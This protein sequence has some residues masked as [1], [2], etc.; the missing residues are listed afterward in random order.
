MAYKGGIDYTDPP[1]ESAD[2][3]TKELVPPW[4]RGLN[5]ANR[6]TDSAPLGG[7][8]AISATVRDFTVAGRQPGDVEL[9]YD[10][11]RTRASDGQRAQCVVVAKGKEGRTDAEKRCY[12]LLVT[13][14]QAVTG[15]RG[16]RVYERVGAGYML[17][18]YITLGTAGIAAKIV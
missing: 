14:T 1:F 6:D 2:W 12:V 3:E 11:D 15:R 16:E 13:P 5:S 18:K 10:T 17:G 7:E 4:T 9:T 8:V